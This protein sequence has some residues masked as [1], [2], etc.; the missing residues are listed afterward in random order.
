MAWI[1]GTPGEVQAQT[2]HLTD[3]MAQYAQLT[4]QPLNLAKSKAV[5]QGDWGPLPITHVGGEGSEVPRLAHGQHV[6]NRTVHGTYA[7]IRTEMPTTGHA[8]THTGGKGTGTGDV[9]LDRWLLTGRRGLQT[10]RGIRR[11]VWGRTHLNF[12]APLEGCVQT[13]NW[14]EPTA[15]IEVLRLVP[16]TMDT[17]IW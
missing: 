13:N 2:L 17:H 7:E 10:V 1:P 11:L 12:S 16:K 5:P 14:A 15:A 8:T 3:I 6:T 9:G 4:G